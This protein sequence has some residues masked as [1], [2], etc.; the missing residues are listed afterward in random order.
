VCQELTQ[1]GSERQ[2]TETARS[3]DRA[4]FT[5]HVACFRPNGIRYEELRAQG[6]PVVTFPITSFGKPAEMLTAALRMG[7]YL[8]QHRIELVHAFDTPGNLFAVP[9]A[10][11]FRV[12]VVLSSQRAFRSLA[13]RIDRHFLRIVDRLADSVVVNCRELAKHLVTDEAEPAGQIRLCYNGID[14]RTF[15]PAPGTRLEPLR[16]ASLVIGTVCALRPEKGLATLA[17][18]FAQISRDAP[19]ARLVMVGSGSMLAKL[20]SMRAASGLE[21]RWL[22]VPSTSDVV[23]WLRSIDIF[24][25]PSLSEALSNSL[26]EAMACGCAAIASRVGGNVELVEDG[27]TGLLFAPANA[28]SLAGA[29]TKLVSQPEARI[30]MAA[31]GSKRIHTFFSR[32]EAAATMAG[33]YESFFE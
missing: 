24:V 20:E 30:R 17:E 14:T 6:I 31:S 5:P 16:D 29:L 23:P 13:S 10:R 3:L 4:R 7:R 11:A 27:E 2:L 26:M 9:V 19:G 12:P 25:L 15:C 22:F 18:A 21:E 8:R 33:I 1:G 32:E 28:A